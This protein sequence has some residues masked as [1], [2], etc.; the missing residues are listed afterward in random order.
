MATARISQNYS[1]MYMYKRSQDM[2]VV[3]TV[4][5]TVSYSTVLYCTVLYS[6]L[7]PSQSIFPADVFLWADFS[8]RHSRIL[9]HI[10][11]QALAGLAPFL[12]LTADLSIL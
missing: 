9:C 7:V 3:K 10:F 11:T 2:L 8:Q 5:L 1:C 4:E 6:V 12:P